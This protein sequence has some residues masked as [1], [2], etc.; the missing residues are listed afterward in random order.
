MKNLVLF[1]ASPFGDEIAQMFRDINARTHEWNIVGF[2]DDNASL[3]G[4]V[5]N[6]APVLGN[7]AWLDGVDISGLWFVCCIGSPKAREKVVTDLNLRGVHFAVGIHPT[8]VMS[9]SVEV[10]AGS[11][12]TAGN[13]LTTNIKIGNHVILNLA[14]TVGHQTLMED[15]VTVNPGAN[16]SGNVTL[17]QGS[18]IGT[19]ATVLEKI[20]VGANSI[21]G[22]CAVINKDLPANVTAVGV[23]GKVIKVHQG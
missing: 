7:R 18:Y 1:G 19:N 9:D 3:T 16:I 23:P 17:R 22:A 12:I 10:G 21:V 14:C 13:I 8:V 4:S 2:L 20:T 11:I 15:Y 6:G 5:R